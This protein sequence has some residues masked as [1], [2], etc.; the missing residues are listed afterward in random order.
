MLQCFPDFMTQMEI[1]CFPFQPEL[2]LLFVHKII[3]LHL[4]IKY[5]NIHSESIC[6]YLQ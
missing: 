4:I 2:H 5:V 3:T 1:L 6:V